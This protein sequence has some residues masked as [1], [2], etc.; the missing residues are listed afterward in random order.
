MTGVV[1]RWNEQ[2]QSSVTLHFYDD[3]AATWICFHSSLQG[4]KK[5]DHSIAGTPGGLGCLRRMSEM[6]SGIEEPQLEAISS[7]QIKTLI[8]RIR[9]VRSMF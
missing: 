6:G 5:Q 4:R 9:I 2:V 1:K 3:I 8:S 7:R